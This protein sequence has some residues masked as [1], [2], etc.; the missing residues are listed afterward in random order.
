MAPQVHYDSTERDGAPSPASARSK[1]LISPFH[2]TRL[3]G[4]LRAFVAS[5]PALLPALLPAYSSSA[6]A[7]ASLTLLYE[8]VAASGRDNNTLVVARGK[9]TAHHN[10]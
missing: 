6:S 1:R 3:H 2:G 7:A 5:A 10:C 9:I 8:D 4:E